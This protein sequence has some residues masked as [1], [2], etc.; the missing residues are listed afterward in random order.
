MAAESPIRKV[1][2]ALGALVGLAGVLAAR[3][4]LAQSSRL[5]L[6]LLPGTTSC[7]SAALASPAAA[8]HSGELDSDVSGT[9]KIA[10]LG[11]SCL[12]F[13]GGSA[14][15][16]P[17]GPLPAGPVSYLDVQGSNLVASAG[18]SNLTCTKGAGPAKHC[19][20]NNVGTGGGACATDVNCNGV[21]GTCALDANCYF[22]APVEL[23]SPPPFNA[24]TSC[25][26][27]VVQADAGGPRRLA[28]GG[29]W[30]R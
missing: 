20:N 24:L 2:L 6:T 27:D 3:P 15:V 25:L 29:R 4:A 22:G 5:S 28:R 9:T 30:T 16:L 12:Y 13:G 18:T 17:P 14:T 10:D 8:P 7:G 21:V 26:V 19:I 11:L 23:F 1:T